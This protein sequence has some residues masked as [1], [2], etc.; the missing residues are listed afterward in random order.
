[1][2]K[3]GN[4]AEKNAERIPLDN[5]ATALMAPA[6]TSKGM[7]QEAGELAVPV[8]HMCPTLAAAQGLD[9]LPKCKE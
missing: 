6:H 7:F 4:N 8:W 5:R 9:D 1:M 2:M 3:M